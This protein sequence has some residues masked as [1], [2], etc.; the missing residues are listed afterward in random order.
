M[1]APLRTCNKCGWVHFAVTR[2]A[3]EAEVEL[4]NS[5]YATLT[6]E[7]QQDYYGGKTSSIKNYEH[8]FFCS[9]IFTNF[10]VFKPG[11]CPDGCTISPIIE[12]VKE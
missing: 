12:E 1:K 2:G 4:F 5:Y 3:A 11:D 7:K 9:N 10:R 8:C 6:P